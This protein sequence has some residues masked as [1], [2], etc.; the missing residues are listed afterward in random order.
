MRAT[1][2]YMSAHTCHI[3]DI[4]Q[5]CI[6]VGSCTWGHSD[7]CH[8]TSIRVKW[9]IYACDTTPSY[10]WHDKFICRTRLRIRVS[11]YTW[12]HSYESHDAFICVT[13]H[14][15]TREMI[16]SYL[17]HD[18][19]MCVT[20]LIHMQDTVAHTCRFVDKSN[21][22]MYSGSKGQVE[23]IHMCDMTHS[24]VWHDFFVCVTL[25]IHMCDMTHPYVWH[26]SF[27]C[28]TWRIHTCDFNYMT[29]VTCVTRVTCVTCLKC[30]TWVVHMCDNTGRVWHESFTSVTIW[31]VCDMCDMSHIS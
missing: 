19:F 27:A 21:G 24:Y 22:F 16:D 10:V 20:W 23:G 12:G 28:A 17:W 8:D 31:D 4:L 18:F 11:S 14:I 13:W 29:C 2:A 3:H 15:H 30:V 7:V 9:F 5:W 6:H 26:D 25:C 1:G